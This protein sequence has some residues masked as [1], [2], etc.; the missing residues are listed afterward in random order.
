ME[1]YTPMIQQYLAIKKEYPDAFLFFRLGDFY[2][3]FFEDAVKA[4]RELE[5][6]L[7]GRDGGG[8]E[9][10][11]MCGVPHHSAEQYIADLVKKGYKVAICEQVEDPKTAKGVVRREVIR[12]VTPGTMMEDTFLA[13]KE[14]NY[15]VAIAQAADRQGVAAADVSTGELFVTSL[16]ADGS[17][18]LEEALQYR[19]SE[20]ILCGELPPSYANGRA[21]VH[22]GAEELDHTAAQ[23]QFAAQ[24]G[25]LDAS[26]LLAVNALLTYITRTQKR[27]LSHLRRISRYEAKQ[28]LQMD[29]F[30]RRNL[31]LTETIRDKQKKGSLLWL[32]DKT[33]TAMGGRLLRRWLERP[34]LD[35]TQ[36]ELR[37][38][39]V[40][41]LKEDML[42]RSEIREVLDR[43]YDLERLAGRI[44]YGSAN[45]RDLLQLRHSLEAIPLLKEHLRA[46]NQPDLVRMAE[47]M[48][49]CS[50]LVDLLA[51]SLVDDPPVS[52]REGGLIRSGYDA[53]LDKLRDASREGKNWIAQLEQ[54][55]RE[56]TGIRSLKVGFNKV[57][58]YYIEVSRP[59]LAA[60][61]EGRYI[62]KQTLANAERF[63]TPE[64]KEKEAL[65]LEAE[66]KMVELEYQLFVAIRS[67]LA[68]HIPRLQALAEQVAT[69]DVLQS[70]ATVSDERRYVRPQFT[71]QGE[72]VIRDGRH[73]VVEAVL[74]QDNYVANDVALD[75]SKRQIL[76]ITGPNMAG[77][78][79]YM[80]QIALI[81]IM[82]QIGC[83]VPAQSA[84]LPLIDQIFTRIGAADD[85]V[86]GHS[87]FMV[88]MLETKNALAKA[89]ARSLILLDEIGRGTS[90]Y[91][92]MALAQAVI[93]YIH[94]HIGAKTLFS[95]HYHELTALAETLPRVVNVNARCE[96]RDGK[97]LFLHKIVEGRADKSYGIHV[98]QLAGLPEPVIARARQILRQLE[99]NR[100]P[101]EGEQISFDLFSEAAVADAGSPFSARSTASRKGLTQPPARLADPLIP[102]AAS[103]V[104]RELLEIDLDRLTPIEALVKLSDW[105]QRLKK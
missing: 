42:L 64:L 61:P 26:M 14:N 32:L 96:E 28:F 91:D 87:T 9:R 22:I 66:E 69:V 23:Q 50:D 18:A 36:I 54:A 37:L 43:V 47:G 44:A 41:Q 98:A 34:L 62:R 16:P 4:A 7:T 99:E 102:T 84:R 33:E 38:Q 80:R 21:T 95:T 70:F 89:T 88:E 17:A 25:E 15:L 90:T 35:R 76:L 2:E 105:K 59:N 77:K 12:V 82:A 68:A 57:F 39:M 74:E 6:T 53:Y 5:I 13:A 73:P 55:E 101:R 71:E 58:G 81:A 29:P 10:I 46:S 65:I 93:E 79:T 94:E 19:P 56:A 63:I 8:T 72:M 75:H 78:S 92:G 20:L 52:V 45:G 104:V 1:Q 31:E 30:S 67:E 51:R 3:L 85:L 40:Q 49:E 24:A 97:L 86:G 100:R 48:D 83:F 27:Q 103:E 60:V 11:P